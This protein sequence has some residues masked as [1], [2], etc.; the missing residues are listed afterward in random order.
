MNSNGDYVMVS[1]DGMAH[2]WDGHDSH[3]TL[4]H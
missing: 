4:D 3:L 2:C 1:C